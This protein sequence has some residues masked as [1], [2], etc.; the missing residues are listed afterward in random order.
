MRKTR[1]KAKQVVTATDKPCSS[2]SAKVDNQNV[3]D[4]CESE[5]ESSGSTSSGS[6]SSDESDS[7]SDMVSNGE[8][9]TPDP[10]RRKLPFDRS[11]GDF[12]PVEV[13]PGSLENGKDVRDLGKL[14]EMLLTNPQAVTAISSMIDVIKAMQSDAQ[15]GRCDVTSDQPVLKPQ[16]EATQQRIPP[17]PPP[18]GPIDNLPGM[19]ETTIY[20]HAIPS[21]S[22]SQE[23]QRG[24]DLCMDRLVVSDNINNEINSVAPITNEINFDPSHELTHNAVVSDAAGRE[25]VR[26]TP[27]DNDPVQQERQA[28]KERTEQMILEA[29]RQKIH[30]E[31]PIMGKRILISPEFK[32][33]LD[34]PGS[35]NLEC[36]NNL[37]G[38]SIH[39]DEGIISLIEAGQ[40]IDLSKL[41]PSDKVVPD[42]E[43][44]RLQ[45]V[46]QDGRLG[47]APYS[48]K[49]SVII[50]GLWT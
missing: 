21:A 35:H 41:A 4:P 48:D 18:I 44:E 8:D 19:S 23:V 17:M 39:L 9:G 33:V 42:D 10:V 30:M 43:P 45:L 37:Y 2:T 38:L 1:S 50:N 22:P 40:F 27:A 20:T 34:Q 16:S 6:S 11:T 26:P 5:G 32:T 15:S 3:P 49:D 28:A 7:D 25:P 14:Q 29:E 46:H 12:Q 31:R 24:R 13:S 36:D 47:V